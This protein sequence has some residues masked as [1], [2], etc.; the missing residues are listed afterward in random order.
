MKYFPYIL[1]TVLSILMTHPSAATESNETINTEQHLHKKTYILPSPINNITIIGNPKQRK[2]IS[3]WLN[4]IALVPKGLSTLQEIARSGHHLTIEHSVA[5]RLSSGRTIA[6]MTQNLTNGIG[7][8]I[9]IIFDG[10][11]EDRGTHR[12]FGSK[13]ELIEFNALQ[14]LYHE[15]AH[16]MHMMNGTWRYFA[17]EKQAIE[18]ENIFRTDLAV[19]NNEEPRLRYRTRGVAITA[20]PSGGLGYQL[21]QVPIK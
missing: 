16:A 11:M 2:K 3:R 18:E 19:I 6:P 1:A 14:N 21:A 5:A 9:K 10:D 12:V 17:S 8:N 13:N 15:L 20:I 4:E 7:D